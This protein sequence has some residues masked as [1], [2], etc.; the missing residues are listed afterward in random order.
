MFK[1]IGAVFASIIL[2]TTAIAHDTT[3]AHTHGMF[4]PNM[5]L[6]ISTCILLLGVMYIGER[7][8]VKRGLKTLYLNNPSKKQKFL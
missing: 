1:L 2:S 8:L 4:G 3:H 5:F 7:T 6:L